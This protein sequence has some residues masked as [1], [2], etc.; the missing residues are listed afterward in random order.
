[1]VLVPEVGSR[2]ATQIHCVEMISGIVYT[3]VI[4]LSSYGYTEIREF[5]AR[6]YPITLGDRKRLNSAIKVWPPS[7]PHLQKL[8][9]TK[10][11][12]TKGMPLTRQPTLLGSNVRTPLTRS[13]PP[14]SPRRNPIDSISI[15]ASH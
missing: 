12:K 3:D 10:Y 2:E 8:V 14:T 9:R 1:M 15:A 13:L 7:G 6:V 5:H 4:S 11:T